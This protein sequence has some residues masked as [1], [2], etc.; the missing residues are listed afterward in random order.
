MTTP[1]PELDPELDRFWAVVPAGGAGTRLWPVSR[2]GHPKFLRDL[3]GSGRTLLQDTV[4]RVQPLVEDRVL[5]V[6]GARHAEAVRR[7]LLDTSVPT[8]NVLAEP[9]PRDS[10]A[11]IGWAAA[12]L[13]RDHPGAIIGSFAAD[14]VIGDQ[15]G[16]EACLVEATR[17]AAAGHL[18]TIGIEPTSAATGFGYIEMGEPLPGFPSARRVRSFVEK[19]DAV[20]AAGYLAAGNY[21]WNAGMFMVQAGTLL[22]LLAVEHPDLA[23]GLRELAAAPE[24]MDE[25][26]PGLQKIA[27]DHA[28]AEPAAAAGQVVCVPGTFEWD[29]VGD[30]AALAG[31]DDADLVVQGDSALVQAIDSTGLVLPKDR[32]IAVLGIEDVVVVD[33]GDAVLVT[34]LAHAQRVKEVV[35]ALQQRGRQDLT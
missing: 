22:D 33:T 4:A 10:M 26:W 11:A 35:T 6:T 9:S 25:I 15:D 16:F 7:Q 12:V 30:F 3:T 17:V 5:V 34:T 13:E 28:V 32:M 8:E 24:R 18:V 1:N 19:P 21:R 29:D 20:R 14:H 27:I 2:N 23:G 31:L